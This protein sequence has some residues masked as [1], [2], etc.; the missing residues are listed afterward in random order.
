MDKEITVED[1]G[2]GG[3]ASKVAV[4]EDIAVADLFGDAESTLE[5]ED[6]GGNDGTALLG[7]TCAQV[8]CK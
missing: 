2:I 6:V 3:S 5:S 7:R 8:A 1:G 4:V